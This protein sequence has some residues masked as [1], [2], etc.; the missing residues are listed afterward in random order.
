MGSFPNRRTPH[1]KPA[2]AQPILRTENRTVSQDNYYETEST[3]HSQHRSILITDF[4]SSPRANPLVDPNERLPFESLQRLHKRRL[5]IANH[6]RSYVI[7]LTPRCPGYFLAWRLIKKAGD[8]T[9]AGTPAHSDP[10]EVAPHRHL[11]FELGLGVATPATVSLASGQRSFGAFRGD[12]PHRHR[13]S[14]RCADDAA[15]SAR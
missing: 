15:P 4:N 3:A 1:T 12:A 10:T 11:P 5:N 2:D 7:P 14:R 9:P 6:S 13:S 8:P